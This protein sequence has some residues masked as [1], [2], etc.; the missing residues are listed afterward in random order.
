[1]HMYGLSKKNFKQVIFCLWTLFV[2]A[3]LVFLSCQSDVGVQNEAGE[4]TFSGHVIDGSNQLP[5]AGVQI[6]YFD[7]SGVS[8]Q[9]ISDS[10]GEFYIKSLPFG[11]RNFHFIYKPA[12][13][14]TFYTQKII[15]AN[16][17]TESKMID[18]LLGDV[19]RVV[20]LYPLNGS[21]SGD[22]SIKINGSNKA[23]PVKKAEIS[24]SYNDTGLINATPVLFNTTADSLGRF[25]FSNLPVAPGASLSINSVALNG[26]VYSIESVSLKEL[27][28]GKMI[29]LGTLFLVSQDTSVLISKVKSN[30]LSTD[31]FGLNSVPANTRLWYILPFKPY[32]A[33]IQVSISDG[34]DPKFS[35]RTNLDTV[36]ITPVKPLNLDTLVT[37]TIEGT[38]TAGNH[39]SFVFDGAK[40]FRTET[41]R[42]AHIKSN[43]LSADGFGLTNVSVNVIPWYKLPVM[44]LASS[45]DVTVNSLQNFT[46][47]L[48]VSKDTVFITPM[49]KFPYDTLVSL[50]I[51]GIDTMR[52]H[53]EYKMD[54][55][56]RFRTEKDP[57]N[58][59][60]S[61]VLSES[62]F[63]L[64]DISVDVH[65]W[66]RLPL[67]PVAAGLSVTVNDGEDLSAKCSIHFDTLF[68]EP[69]RKL[70]YD[71]LITVTISGKDS[72]Q[73]PF[74]FVFDNDR[75]FRTSAEKL[76]EVISN[77]LSNDGKGLTGIPVNTRLWYVLPTP[78]L[79]S[80]VTAKISG[81]G[82]PD[83]IININKDTVF[84]T[85][86]RLFTYESLI[87]VTIQGM[88]TSGKSFQ[89]IFDSSKRFTTEKGI[90]PNASNAWQTSGV[91]LRT[92]KL[93]DTIWVRY[94]EILDADIAKIDW[95]TSSAQYSIY[96][97]GTV[98]N[99]N[100]WIKKDTL[101]VRPD[102]RLAIG[103]GQTMGF[104]VSVT[105][106][107]GKRS[108][109]TDI[110]VSTVENIYY[111]KWTNTKDFL[112]N[113]RNDFGARDSI[114]VVSN[115]PIKEIRGLSGI[116]GKAVP[117]GLSLDNIV[118]HGDTIIYK[119]SLYMKPDSTYGLDFDVL[120]KDGSLL[121]DVLGVNWKTALKIKI[122]DVNN[123]ING[124]YRQFKVKGDSLTVTFSEAV[125]TSAT[126]S[127]PFRVNIIDVKNRQIKTSVRWDATCKIAKIF[128]LD[129]LPTADFDASPAYTSGSVYTR[130]VNS[131]SFNMIT[132][133]GEQVMN[134]KPRNENIELHTE[135]G[136]CVVN[137]NLLINHDPH[138]EVDR[139]ENTTDNF[140]ANGMVQL[141]FNR[142]LD[143]MAIRE[144]T[145]T[146][147][148]Y[149]G[150]NA[151]TTAISSTL[152]FS[153]D[154]KT[155]SIKPD[156][157]LDNSKAYYVWIKNIPGYQI[158]GA[159]AINKHAGT[160]NGKAANYSLFDKAFMVK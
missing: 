98:A 124:E 4:W 46:V 128:N 152:L 130:A 84:I 141:L 122:L 75:R 26:N 154:A 13:T 138:W 24:I 12:K 104:R 153:A 6:S 16:S 160:F 37:V 20:T 116:N 140:P 91:P 40:R 39:F 96:G 28:K 65:P 80:S 137:T 76:K 127:I 42:S 69:V 123:R 29:L 150:I 18:G 100:V 43:V 14:S 108:D 99:A 67:F 159:P 105:S 151:G 19:S 33:G 78:P 155:I 126:A 132:R 129:M 117:D 83:P 97:K 93:N 64:T 50:I 145:S 35:V 1:M 156:S 72:T 17:Y 113:M 112:G 27:F 71:S 53:F 89:Y 59:V 133:N 8:K 139:G 101:F 44:P 125:D 110:I 30:V 146:I 158:T 90:F 52:N 25:S 74:K 70:K 119:P 82:D 3:G 31:G 9:V 56:R 121:Y 66:Y 103:F 61:N 147:S 136:L 115:A 94:S 114:I 54:D 118:L 11:D 36:F 63:G 85:P 73:K 111:V 88:D 87:T 143:T 109:T 148:K 58:L 107:S 134:F 92:F 41:D 131:I 22:V 34:S 77:V 144:D 149:I 60:S 57:V 15:Q 86:S 95:L 55:V 10:S 2:A 38:D 62:G 106:A 135:R 32:P 142:E 68:I 23:V 47:K 120:F 21:V 79:S 49:G 102:Q 48:K 81:G 45:V 157:L 5:L 51:S 7:N